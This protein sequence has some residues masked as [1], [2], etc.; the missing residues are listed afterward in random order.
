MRAIWRAGS[1]LAGADPSCVVGR[2]RPPVSATA[3]ATATA[4]AG[5][6]R[7][8]PVPLRVAGV[9][10]SCPAF[11]A[12]APRGGDRRTSRRPRLVRH[13]ASQASARRIKDTGGLRGDQACRRR[14]AHTMAALAPL[15]VTGERRPLP[16]QS[17]RV[18]ALLRQPSGRRARSHAM[19]AVQAAPPAMPMTSAMVTAEG[20]AASAVAGMSQGK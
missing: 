13:P 7:V 16:T 20:S 3:A 2:C 12:Q 4:A 14:G 5:R 19:A 11:C 17:G 18:I 10:C 9:R 1:F 6:D 15:S 8:R